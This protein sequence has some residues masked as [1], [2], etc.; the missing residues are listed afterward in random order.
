[1]FLYMFQFIQVIS[2][3]SSAMLWTLAIGISGNKKNKLGLWGFRLTLGF[4]A[5]LN[6]LLFISTII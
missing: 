3:L 4:I 1:M 6:T 2:L 5:L